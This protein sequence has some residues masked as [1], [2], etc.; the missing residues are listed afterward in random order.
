M[1]KISTAKDNHHISNQVC[2]NYLGKTNSTKISLSLEAQKNHQEIKRIT[3]D[4][5][6]N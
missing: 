6:K 2:N 3:T 4:E 5:K 1:Q